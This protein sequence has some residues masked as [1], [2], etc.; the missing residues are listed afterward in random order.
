MVMKVKRS[1]KVLI[2]L[3]LGFVTALDHISFQCHGPTE[4]KD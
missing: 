3:A 2:F 1:K 4:V